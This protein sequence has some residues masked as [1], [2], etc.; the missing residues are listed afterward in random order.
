MH[1]APRLQ[2]RR[3]FVA[4]LTRG[5]GIGV[6][7]LGAMQLLGGPGGCTRRAGEVVA[8]TSVDDVLAR[9]VLEA[10]RRATGVEVVAVFDTEATKTTGLENRVRAE[11]NRPRAD[12]FWSSE[13]FACARLASDG[14]LQQLPGD[15]LAGWP[16]AHRDPQGR[17][18]GFS[19][20]ARVVA[21]RSDRALRPPATWG[22]LA[23]VD[24]AVRIAI[25]DPRFGTTRGH[26]AALNAAWSSARAGARAASL[27]PV[28]VTPGI[29]QWADG[30]RARGVRVLTGGNAATVEAVAA[31]EVDL[32]LTD[33]DDVLAAQ[34]RGLPLAFT[35]PRTLPV[36]VAGG[37]T[38]LV[39]N[40][41][42]LVAGR[43]ARPEVEA[44]LRWLVSGDG[45]RIICASPSRNIPLGPGA[46]EIAAS[47]SAAFEERDAL[48][49]DL[50][51]AAREAD[52]L[53]ARIHRRLV[54]NPA[55]LG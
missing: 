36:G 6:P 26:I 55:G 39:P 43:D 17:W 35:L 5:I 7:A 37:G 23:T 46:A 40:T 28:D 18:I 8:Y 22:E 29:E 2:T 32:G 24:P 4:T 38:M 30:L 19:G 13:A 34:A 10:C 21:Y 50:A 48:A 12:L 16:A 1:R 53:A 15:L 41:I 25:A 14:L 47:C 42:G 45:E 33:T 52:E 3:D 20:R 49:F 9:E 27:Q 44:V 54:G 31:G 11:A 51:A